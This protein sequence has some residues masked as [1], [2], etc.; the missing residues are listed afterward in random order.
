[1][2]SV[3]TLAQALVSDL[4]G[5]GYPGMQSSVATAWITREGIGGKPQQAGAAPPTN[6]LGIRPCPGC[7]GSGLEIGS[8]NGFA[9]YP[10]DLDGI[11]AAAYLLVH[12][13]AY[14]GVLQAVR[15]GNA[16]AQAVAIIDSHW[17]GD[18]HY[19]GHLGQW[20]DP[21]YAKSGSGGSSSGSGNLPAWGGLVSFPVGHILTQA[22]VQTIM[23]ALTK[24]GYFKSDWSGV[25]QMQAYNILKSGIGMAWTPDFLKA[26]QAAFLGTAASEPGANVDLAGAIAGIPVALAGIPAA[27]AGAVAPVVL[28]LGILGLAALLI[29]TGVR[30][31]IGEAA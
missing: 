17:D 14:S 18:G 12:N 8:F 25:A 30:R 13:P 6:P 16:Q 26:A 28:N 21:N 24:A 3:P 5:M 2:S 27:L 19:A 9:S 15:S 11:R 10:T 4:A 23:D 7:S 29:Y 22:D 1:M 31:V 20:S